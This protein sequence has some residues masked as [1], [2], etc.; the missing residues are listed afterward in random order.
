MG[1]RSVG[2][3]TDVYCCEHVVAGGEVR[4][5]AGIGKDD[6]AVGVGGVASGDEEFGHVIDIGL[7]ATEGMF[8]TGV[9]YADEEGFTAHLGGLRGAV[10]AGEK[11]V[12]ARG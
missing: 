6:H 7:T 12:V 4:A 3:E 11:W 2:G 9:V 5:L 1:L 10:T 8:A